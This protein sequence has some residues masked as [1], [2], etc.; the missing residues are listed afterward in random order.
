MF[1]LA[2]GYCPVH[3]QA[4]RQAV[5]TSA[6]ALIGLLAILG[7]L[8]RVHPVRMYSAR[9]SDASCA[10]TSKGISKICQVEGN[11]DC[12]SRNNVS[13]TRK[14]PSCFVAKH[15]LRSPNPIVQL[16]ACG[17]CHWF[18]HRHSEALLNTARQNF[19]VPP[20]A[21]VSRGHQD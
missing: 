1:S 3:V 17:R 2:L 18:S 11:S 5:W 10:S 8:P 21:G 7:S 14:D 20:R 15:C 6:P 16:V 12:V 9:L 13:T 4:S 19:P